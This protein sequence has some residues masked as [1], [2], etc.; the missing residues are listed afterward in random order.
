LT[1]L[2][3]HKADECFVVSRKKT[4]KTIFTFSRY[5]CCFSC[6]FDAVLSIISPTCSSSSSSSSSSS[7]KKK[8]LYPARHNYKVTSAPPSRLTLNKQKCLQ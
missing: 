1:E 6:D 4:M 7:K 5:K 3:N 2:N 8:S